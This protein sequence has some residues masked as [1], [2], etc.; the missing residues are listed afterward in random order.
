MLDADVQ[1]LS[2]AAAAAVMFV[3]GLISL[4]AED[5][6]LADSWWSGKP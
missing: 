3:T 5:A 1:L 2:L 4:R 6:S